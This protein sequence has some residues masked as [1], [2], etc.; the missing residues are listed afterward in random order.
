MTGQK[1]RQYVYYWLPGSIYEYLVP[2]TS[3]DVLS[4]I[5]FHYNSMGKFWNVY[6]S[7]DTQ[8]IAVFQSC[9]VLQGSYWVMHEA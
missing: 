7:V 8:S 9:V 2:Y 6:F 4:F 3:E 5:V 1:I